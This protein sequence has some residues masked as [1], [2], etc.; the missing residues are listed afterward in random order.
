MTNKP[1]RVIFSPEE[2]RAYMAGTKTQFRRVVKF[3]K[4][5][6]FDETGYPFSGDGY[7]DCRPVEAA[8]IEKWIRCPFGSPGDTLYVAETWYNDVPEEQNLDYI[9][10]RATHKCSDWEGECPCRDA[11]GRSV[12]RSSTSMPRWASRFGPLVTEVRVQQLQD[13]TEEECWAEGCSELWLP[14]HRMCDVILPARMAT[15]S[16]RFPDQWDS[17]NTTPAHTWDANPWVWAV[18]VTPYEKG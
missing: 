18:T 17:R 14:E 1:H 5:L 15:G 2:V 11:E 13:I 6:W 4:S 7:T 9:A 12:W 8:D 16:E 10:Y 3:P